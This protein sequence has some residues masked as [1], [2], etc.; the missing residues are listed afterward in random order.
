MQD[1]RHLGE[2]VADT[3]AR[4]TPASGGRTANRPVADRAQRARSRSRP[5][6]LQRAAARGGGEVDVGVRAGRAAAVGTGPCSGLAPA[7]LR[8]CASAIRSPSRLW[9]EIV[10]RSPSSTKTLTIFVPAILAATAC[11]R[12]SIVAVRRRASIGLPVSEADLADRPDDLVERVARLHVHV[13]PRRGAGAGEVER[14][15]AA[16]G[17]DQVGLRAPDRVDEREADQRVVHGHDA[18]PEP[19]PPQD[20]PRSCTDGHDPARHRVHDGRAVAASLDRD[21]VAAGRA[22][23]SAP[24]A[25][26]RRCPRAAAARRR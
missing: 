8:P 4:A 23:R 17:D 21:R 1:P 14:V 20:L 15:G 22:V 2:R 24:S 25:R 19:E 10:E 16:R 12:A 11:R 13:G 6:L 5:E 18:A 26:R 3:A 7:T 9:L